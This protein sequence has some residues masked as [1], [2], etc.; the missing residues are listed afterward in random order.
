V[1]ETFALGPFLVD[2]K[3]KLLFHGSEPVRLGRRSIALLLALVERR[4]AVVSKDALIEAAWPNLVVQE[5]N[6]GVQIAA[7]RRVLCETPGGDRWIETLPRRGYR[8]IGPAVA[9][10]EKSIASA[11]LKVDTAL[12]LTPTQ[13]SDAERRQITAMSCELVG[14]ARSLDGA[15]LEAKREAGDAFRHCLSEVVRRHRGFIAGHLGN[16]ALIF[17]GYPAAHEHDAEH[18]VRAGL[19]LSAAIRSLTACTQALTRC[20]VGIATGTVI[21]GDAMDVGESRDY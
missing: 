18:A 16:T 21:I 12:D 9:E 20:R 17:F 4:G 11:P 14:N 19:E 3:N 13:H 15:D 6:L 7:L 10:V 2:I 5:A 8:F 1:Q